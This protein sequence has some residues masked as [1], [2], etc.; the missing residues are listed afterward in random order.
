MTVIGANTP[1]MIR[2]MTNEAESRNLIVASMHRA[3]KD[4]ACRGRAV[5]AFALS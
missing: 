1:A 5:L 3:R 2:S 4:L